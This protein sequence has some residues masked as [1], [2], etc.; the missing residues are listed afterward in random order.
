MSGGG[1]LKYAA[2]T[3]IFLSKKKVTEGEGKDKE[4]VGSILTATLDKSRFTRYGLKADLLLSH[5]S[6]LDKYWGLFDFGLE[7]GLLT[8]GTGLDKGKNGIP[9][10]SYQFPGGQIG[11]RK[12]IDANPAQFFDTDENFAAFEE[13][14]AKSFLFGTGDQEV[15]IE[16]EVDAEAETAQVWDS[17]DAIESAVSQMEAEFDNDEDE[18]PA[19][20]K[21]GKK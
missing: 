6:G 13:Q 20:K 12:E 14:C 9:F 7:Y 17:P 18:A 1:G 2:S 11:T 3:I 19:L 5:G 10:N 16:G 8:K 15:E 21:K 4:V